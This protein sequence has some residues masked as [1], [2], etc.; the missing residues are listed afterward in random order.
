MHLLLLQGDFPGINWTQ[1]GVAGGV[2][3]IVIVFLY[4]VLKIVPTLGAI[5]E[6]VKTAEIAV[7][8]K[9]AEAR[10]KEAESRIQQATGFGQL[11]TALNEQS[12]VIREVVV[13]QRHATDK[14][15]LMSRVNA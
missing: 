8:E 3:I 5:Y 7:R 14:A 12:G 2:I 13:E 9:E 1:F 11:A 10:L 4:F 6:K 15:M